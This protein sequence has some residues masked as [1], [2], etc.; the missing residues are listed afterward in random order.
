MGWKGKEGGG[1]GGGGG[2]DLDRVP[3]PLQAT[4]SEALSFFLTKRICL[5]PLAHPCT[6]QLSCSV[7]RSVTAVLSMGIPSALN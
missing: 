4:V 2:Q 6:D 5:R 3:L 7:I 1:T